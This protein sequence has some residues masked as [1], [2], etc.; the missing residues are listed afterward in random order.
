MDNNDG[1]EMSA[2]EKERLFRDL[3]YIK[4]KLES[5]DDAQRAH[6]NRCTKEM[7]E[8]WDVARANE[9]EVTKIK[10]SSRRGGA[11]AGAMVSGA[12]V[13]AWEIIRTVVL[14]K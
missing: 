5:I 2:G 12:I 13:A 4:A 11:G 6:L 3:G 8:V 14:G 9:T 1:L 7:G 10:S